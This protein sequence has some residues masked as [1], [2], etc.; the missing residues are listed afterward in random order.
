MDINWY[1]IQTQSLFERKVTTRLTECGIPTFLPTYEAPST[2]KDRKQMLIKPLFSGYLFVHIPQEDKIR[3]LTNAHVIRILGLVPDS[4]IETLQ[5]AMI[6][7]SDLK[8][9]HNIETG[10]MVRINTGSFSGYKG[11]LAHYKGA[12]RVVITLEAINQQFSIEVDETDVE[13]IH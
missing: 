6:K 12:S 7:K 2:R 13:V 11:L 10:S 8:P 5:T 4:D 9:V 3:V 1:A